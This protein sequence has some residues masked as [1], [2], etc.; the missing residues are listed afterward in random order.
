M[1]GLDQVLNLDFSEKLD[2]EGRLYEVLALATFSVFLSL[3]KSYIISYL[4]LIF[5]ILY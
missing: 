4:D 1:L 5:I 3:N 2:T